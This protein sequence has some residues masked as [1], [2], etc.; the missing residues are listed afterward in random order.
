[1]EDDKN[2]REY[3]NCKVKYKYLKPTC[4]LIKIEHVQIKQVSQKYGDIWEDS[5]YLRTHI[6]YYNKEFF[7]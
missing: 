1:M 5:Y 4:L 2:T 6:K 3:H 7:N